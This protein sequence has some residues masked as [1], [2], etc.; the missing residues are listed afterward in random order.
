MVL[1]RVA[2]GLWIWNLRTKGIDAGTGGHMRSTHCSL[3]GWACR[4]TWQMSCGKASM[5]RDRALPC[6]KS[7]SRLVSM[8]VSID[9]LCCLVAQLWCNHM[10]CEARLMYLVASSWRRSRSC[11]CWVPDP[12]LLT[13]KGED[14]GECEKSRCDDQERHK[15]P[16]RS[17][18]DGHTG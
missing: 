18:G 8:R 15:S 6:R 16:A 2:C 4:G 7:V 11:G 13:A 1:A 5:L 9:V 3:Q 17:G 12:N 14:K 10:S